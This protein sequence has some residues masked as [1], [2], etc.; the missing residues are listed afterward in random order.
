MT[1]TNG[2]WAD[3]G[4]DA[5]FSA[6]SISN[7]NTRSI[8]LN[9]TWT[10]TGTGTVWNAADTT[11]LTFAANNSIIKLTNTSG[12]SKTFAGGGL[13]YY[14]VWIDTGAG[15]G[16]DN[17]ITGSNNYN[18]FRADGGIILAWT[19][20][21][22]NTAQDWDISGFALNLNTLK[23]QGASAYTLAKAANV[24]TIAKIFQTPIANVAKVNQYAQ[25]PVVNLD[26]MDVSDCTGSPASTWF[27]GA[28]SVNSGG[29]TNWTFAAST[30][31]GLE[32]VFQYDN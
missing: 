26:Y 27:A 21:T 32:K 9:S 20:G 14:N 3:A 1:L 13:T 19:S 8:D 18:Q 17:I 7:A 4:Y 24:T 29:N 10:L 6:V 2:S 5:T 28:N 25:P 31:P 12:S 15:V 23:R 22:T 11:N 30:D 16:S